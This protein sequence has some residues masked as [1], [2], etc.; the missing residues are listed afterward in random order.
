MSKKNW[1]NLSQEVT[2]ALCG[3]T[4]PRVNNNQRF[5]SNKC[6]EAWW[7]NPPKVKAICV[8]CNE[9]FDKRP[10]SKTK[11]C[12]KFCGDVYNSVEQQL[13]S[14]EEIIHLILLNRGFGLG[15]FARYLFGKQKL[16]AKGARGKFVDRLL[17]ICEMAKEEDNLDLFSILNDPSVLIEMKKDEW[18][19][20][21]RPDAYVP[22]TKGGKTTDGGKGRNTYKRMKET[23]AR[24]E[25][26]NFEFD[27]YD[28]RTGLKVRV[29]P[30]FNWGPYKLRTKEGR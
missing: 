7:A 21:G 12:G 29:Y 16:G 27:R 28:R 24:H 13:W 25:Q 15:R 1:R 11:T 20:K 9:E 17:V 26:S 14:D 23:Y 22:G 18:L 30:E 5:C 3:T 6:R 8:V 4:V 10:R 2:C 19:A